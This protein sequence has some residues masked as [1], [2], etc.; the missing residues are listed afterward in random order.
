[1]YNANNYVDAL[2]KIFNY[3]AWVKIMSECAC[4]SSV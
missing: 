2:N 3:D 4:I 1:M